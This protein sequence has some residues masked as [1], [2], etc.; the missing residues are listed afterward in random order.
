MQIGEKC[1]RRT[2]FSEREASERSSALPFGGAEQSSAHQY[3]LCVRASGPAPQRDF[4]LGIV[5]T[6]F[7]ASLRWSGMLFRPPV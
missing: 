7:G 2:R 6:L 3:T 5:R 4:V 1:V